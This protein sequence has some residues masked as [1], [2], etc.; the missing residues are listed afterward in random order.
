VDEKLRAP[1]FTIGSVAPPVDGASITLDNPLGLRL[2][3]L[4]MLTLDC[5]LF[6]ARTAV[7][8]A[9]RLAQTIHQLVD[10]ERILDVDRALDMV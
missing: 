3:N 8:E 2:T 4:D 10:T 1:L 6:S 5:T 7:K 9:V